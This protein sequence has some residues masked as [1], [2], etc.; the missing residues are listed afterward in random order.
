MYSWVY[1]QKAISWKHALI[2]YFHEISES[3]L[4]LNKK[5]KMIACPFWSSPEQVTESLR[6]L[7]HTHIRSTTNHYFHGSINI[8]VYKEK[9]IKYWEKIPNST[10]LRCPNF[11]KPKVQTPNIFNYSGTRERLPFFP[12]YFAWKMIKVINQLS[13]IIAVHFSVD[14]PID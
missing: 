2:Q 9:I 11:V 8:F 10:S 7:Q 1:L 5:N 12:Q 3:W 6:R 13:K 4:N 14:W